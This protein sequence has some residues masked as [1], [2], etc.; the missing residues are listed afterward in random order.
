M[1]R[2]IISRYIEMPADVKYR[3]VFLEGM[4]GEGSLRH[5]RMDPG[6]RAKIFAPFAALT[7]FDAELR[8]KDIRYVEK[9]I[10]SEEDYER[11][12][13][14]L[15]DIK[16]HLPQKVNVIWFSLCSDPDH[17]A[18][19]KLGREM[20][21]SGKLLR[22]DDIFGELVFVDRMIQRKDI[23]DITVENNDE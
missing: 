13:L 1:G 14:L 23:L 21:Y 7:G 12:N 18:Y 17:D 20:Q 5:P 19:R 8:K 15:Q 4:H 3:D 10:L 22:I 6:K 2:R 9:R 16:D 11:I